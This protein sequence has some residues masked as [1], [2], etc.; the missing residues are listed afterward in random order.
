MNCEVIFQ[1]PLMKVE[2]AKLQLGRR[3][4]NNQAI[5]HKQLEQKISLRDYPPI[6]PSWLLASLKWS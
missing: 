1:Q 4:G 3:I 6:E 5:D 2:T